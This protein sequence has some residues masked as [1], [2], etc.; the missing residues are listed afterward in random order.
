LLTSAEARALLRVS[1]WKLEALIRDG[2]LDGTIKTGDA[3]NSHYRIP[4]E[5]VSAYL[6]RHK[7]VPATVAS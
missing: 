7:V 4:E 1:R 5:A 6:E 2:E 3:S